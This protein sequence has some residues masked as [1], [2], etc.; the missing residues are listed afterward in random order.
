MSVKLKDL[1]ALDPKWAEDLKV[2]FGQLG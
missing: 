1:A 2:F